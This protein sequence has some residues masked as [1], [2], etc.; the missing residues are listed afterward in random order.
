MQ[1]L[2]SAVLENIVNVRSNTSSLTSNI[3]VG[4]IFTVVLAVTRL[5]RMH[6]TE[7]IGSAEL[8]S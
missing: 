8:P 6:L 1:L 2:G 5:N 7:H 3:I 4:I